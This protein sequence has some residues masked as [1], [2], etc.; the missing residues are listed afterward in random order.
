MFVI[1]NGFNIPCYKFEVTND[2][3]HSTPR[4]YFTQNFN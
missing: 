3:N 1:G 4:I 2:R